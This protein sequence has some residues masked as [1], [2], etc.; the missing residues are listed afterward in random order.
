MTIEPPNTPVFNQI[1]H[2]SGIMS[3]LFIDDQHLA[4]ETR[5]GDLLIF[6]PDDLISDG[7][8][9]KPAKPLHSLPTGQ[10]I[11]QGL[12]ISPD[13]AWLAT[14]GSKG[15]IVLWTWQ[16]IDRTEILDRTEIFRGHKGR[17]YSVAFCQLTANSS[18]D[19]NCIIS[20]SQDKDVRLWKLPTMMVSGA[21]P[22]LKDADLHEAEATPYGLL[23]HGQAI[24]LGYLPDG[25]VVAGVGTTTESDKAQSGNIVFWKPGDAKPAHS[26]NV[27]GGAPIVS[28][29]VSP[30]GEFVATSSR[31]RNL[32]LLDVNG[33][34]PSPPL[35]GVSHCRVFASPA[36]RQKQMISRGPVLA[37]SI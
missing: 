16:D 36:F 14:S 5:D 3:L 1:V 8:D 25:R 34:K 21:Q 18:Q 4:V 33:K 15:T 35:F 23:V 32:V 2:V 26:V 13:L 27:D 30:D 10:G 6:N 37:M 17:V 29:A 20:A 22:K 11:L 19:S 9:E 28:F 7:R 24:G 12:A 31:N